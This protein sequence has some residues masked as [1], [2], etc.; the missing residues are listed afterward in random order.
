MRVKNEIRKR[1]EIR[2]K[3]QPVDTN[4]LELKAQARDMQAAIRNSGVKAMKIEDDVLKVEEKDG[5]GMLK[6]VKKKEDAKKKEKV[7]KDEK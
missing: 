3:E 1:V 7:K 6:D 4:L 5:D 2:K